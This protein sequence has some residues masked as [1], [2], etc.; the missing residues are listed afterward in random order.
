M[1]LLEWD[2]LR[3]QQINEERNNKAVE[4]NTKQNK[5]KI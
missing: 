1:S 4:H 2:G 5:I 3:V